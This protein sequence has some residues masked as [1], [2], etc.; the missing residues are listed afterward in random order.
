[1]V[2]KRILLSIF[3]LGIAVTLAGAGTWAA[4]QDTETSTGNTFSSGTLDMKLSN[5]GSTY[6]DGVTATWSSP[7]FKPGD[8]FANEIRFTNVGTININHLYMYPEDLTNS[9]G[10][11]NIQLSD[12]IYLTKI[13]GH[14][15]RDGSDLQ[16]G[17]RANIIARL[18]GDHKR[19]LTLTEFCESKYVAYYTQPLLFGV[20]PPVLKG[21]NHKDWGLILEGQFDPDADNDYQGASCSFNLKCV[22]SQNSPTEGYMQITDEEITDE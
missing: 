15:T 5:D 19:P 13:R 21:G 22:G 11:N 4:F 12:K 2:N 7:N 6:T 1:M 20:V 17:N 8:T 10:T 16:W 9:G 18:V 14:I 3:V